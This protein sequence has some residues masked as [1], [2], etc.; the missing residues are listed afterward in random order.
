MLAVEPRPVDRRL[1]LVLGVGVLVVALVLGGLAVVDRLRG[2]ASS[3]T[4]LASGVVTALDH[5]DLGALARL[6]EPSERAALAR[7]GSSLAQRLVDLD[8]PQAVGGGRAGDD[9]RPLDGL[10]LTLTGAS[11]RVESEGG[12]VAVVGLGDL[13][14]RV[15]SDPA[16]AHGL[17]RTWLAR[18]RVS[19]PEVESYGVGDLPGLGRR[20][21]LVAVERGGRWYVSVLATLLGPA[22]PAGSPTA[23][24]A[25]EPTPAPDPQA[26]V[27]S[28]LRALLDP[29]ARRDAVPLARTL[30]ASGSDVV[31]LWAGRLA[32]SG[33]DRSSPQVSG[34][35]TT[36][37]PSEGGR[38]VVRVGA[39]RLGTSLDLAGPCATVGRRTSCLRPTPYRY[40]GGAG[41]LGAL[42]LLGHDGA[43]SLTAVQDGDGWRTSLPESVADAVLG[44]ARGLSRAQVLMV[45]NAERSDVPSGVLDPDVVRDVTFT[46]GG[47]AL[48]TLRVTRAGLY[49]VVPSPAAANRAIVYAPDGQPGLQPFFPNDSVYRLQPGDHTLL[50]WADDAFSATLRTGVPYVQPVGVRAIR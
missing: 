26:A 16:R 27:E 33:P 4:R 37:G 31:Q 40:A 45:L 12:G 6:V 35:L 1:L 2:G 38:T 5:E 46:D 17:L 44:Y 21:G 29:Q 32:L 11:P 25:L 41:T 48:L 3:P 10:D 50:V 42:E 36:P 14:V 24:E 13:V 49:R 39:L 30:D 20:T 23:V 18:E 19:E 15:R 28:T 43:F 8:L 22:V 34:L 9:A 7:L 47:Y